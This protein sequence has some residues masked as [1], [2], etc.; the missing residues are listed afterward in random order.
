MAATGVIPLAIKMTPCMSV[1][2]GHVDLASNN[3]SD[4]SNAGTV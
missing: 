3:L 4:P 1:R 2:M